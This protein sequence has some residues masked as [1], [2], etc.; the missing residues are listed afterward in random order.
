LTLLVRQTR[1]LLQARLLWERAGRPAFRDVRGFQARVAG[2]WEA[3]VFGQGADDVT[4]IHP[5]AAFKRFEAAR[6][7]DLRE[8][9]ETL[10]RLRRAEADLK[11]GAA[12]GADQVVED[13][14]LEL[15]ARGRRAA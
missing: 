8:L 12:E 10:V 5:F 1:H 6:A 9:R 3:G 2:S 13:L 11:T 15:A 7:H 4:T 14:V